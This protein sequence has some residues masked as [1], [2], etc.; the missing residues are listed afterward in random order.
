M[1]GMPLASMNDATAVAHHDRG[2]VLVS[3][4]GKRIVIRIPHRVTVTIHCNDTHGVCRGS[5]GTLFPRRCWVGPGSGQVMSHGALA[6][7]VRHRDWAGGLD[8]M[9]LCGCV[10]GHGQMQSCKQRFCT[11]SRALARRGAGRSPT[12]PGG[13][14]RATAGV[15]YVPGSKSKKCGMMF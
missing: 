6:A 5:H 2:S 7:H 4:K 14:R 1:R 13:V 3:A 15:K 9:L 12:P 8:T 10:Q 11:R